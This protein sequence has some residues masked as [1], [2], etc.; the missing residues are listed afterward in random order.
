M[1]RVAI[2]GLRIRFLAPLAVKLGMRRPT[3]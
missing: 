3:T 1:T 2:Q